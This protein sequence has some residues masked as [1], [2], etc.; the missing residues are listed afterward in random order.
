[1]RREFPTEHQYFHFLYI[2]FPICLFFLIIIQQ[3]ESSED[4]RH[5]YSKG[6]SSS[7]MERRVAVK[8]FRYRPQCVELHFVFKTNHLVFYEGQSA[9]SVYPHVC[10]QIETGHP[11]PCG[12]LMVG[13]VTFPVRPLVYRIIG[14]ALRRQRA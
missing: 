10:L 3:T 2:F 11:R 8:Q 12:T 13:I 5:V 9:A 14:T 7:A 1:M 6:Y 4:S